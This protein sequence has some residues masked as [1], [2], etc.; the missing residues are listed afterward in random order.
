MNS[1]VLRWQ[2]AL[3]ILH[4][5]LRHHL[6]PHINTTCNTSGNVPFQYTAER[7]HHILIKVWSHWCLKMRNFAAKSIQLD[8]INKMSGSAHG[9]SWMVQNGGRYCSLL[10]VISLVHLLCW[11]MYWPRENK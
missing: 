1:S 7:L 10:A 8:T 2:T 3:L 9:E 6:T 5:S 4:V 11:K